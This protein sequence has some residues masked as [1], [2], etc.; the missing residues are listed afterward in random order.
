MLRHGLKF[1]L[2]PLGTYEYNPS[3]V[4]PLWSQSTQLRAETSQMSFLALER[5]NGQGQ[6]HLPF[7][8][9]GFLDKCV[10]DLVLS[11][12]V[13]HG[14]ILRI[15]AVLAVVWLFVSLRLDLKRVSHVEICHCL[16]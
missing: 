5:S 10:D 14:L 4:G 16:T 7:T 13:P 1:K 8:Y 11:Q 9:L 15:G 6:G 12:P 3:F 2:F